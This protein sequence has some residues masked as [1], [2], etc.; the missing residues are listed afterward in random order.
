MIM[1]DDFIIAIAL[2]MD[3]LTVSISG[4]AAL[5]KT[6]LKKA[7]FV[8]SYFGF[9]QF[10]MPILGWYGGMF[11]NKIIDSYDHWI[12]FGL[13]III[14]GKMILEF[15]WGAEEKE[16]SL[17]HKLLFILSIATSIDA[18]GVGLSYAFLNKAIMTPSIIIGIVTFIFSTIG[19]YLGKSLKKVLKNKAEFVGGIILMAIGI[20]ILINHGVFK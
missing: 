15:F 4:G 2:A 1:I 16:F 17:N 11:F 5:N 20:N 3:A 12:A 10:F 8:A 13:L 18:L 6:T 9:F 7:L 14:G 19:V